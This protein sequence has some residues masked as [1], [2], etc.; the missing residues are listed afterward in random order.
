MLNL[1]DVAPG[2]EIG[3]TVHSIDMAQARAHNR[4]SDIRARVLIQPRSGLS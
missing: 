1:L 2:A 4:D 3:I